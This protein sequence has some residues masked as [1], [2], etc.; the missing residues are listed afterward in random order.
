MK[1]YL[2]AIAT[3][4]MT[5]ASVCLTSCGENEEDPIPEPQPDPVVRTFTDTLKLSATIPTE[6]K[7]ML[8]LHYCVVDQDGEKEVDEIPTI[9]EVHTAVGVYNRGIKITSDFKPGSKENYEDYKARVQG[10]IKAWVEASG[11]TYAE[12]PLKCKMM[13]YF[14]NPVWHVYK[15]TTWLDLAE[16]MELH[17]G[18]CTEEEAFLAIT[19]N[20]FEELTY[21]LN[22]WSFTTTIA[23]NF[24]DCKC[25]DYDWKNY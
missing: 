4:C 10:E 23:E 13:F 20:L 11:M 6:V 24:S 15:N 7:E 3:I 12:V 25:V 19:H 17:E 9:D 5:A 22:H 1:K 8:K 18:E 2:L 21:P 16:Y 14:N